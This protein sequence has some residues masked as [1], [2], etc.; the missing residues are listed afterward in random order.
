MARPRGNRR[1]RRQNAATTVT[2]VTM[3]RG[4]GR[5]ARRGTPGQNAPRARRQVVTQTTTSSTNVLPPRP[6][7]R[8]RLNRSYRSGIS[9]Q[10]TA[11]LGTV[12][13][14]DGKQVELEMSSILNPAL[15]KETTGA[16][17]FGPLQIYA[18]TYTLWKLER[19]S[20][21]L[22]PLV[23][24]S[25][26]SGTAVRVSFTP[27][28]QPGSPSWSA[29][30]AR[31]HAD[32]TPG[33]QITFSLKGSDLKGPKEGWFFCN[34]SN[35]PADCMGGSIQVHTFGAT[36]STYKNEAF[37]GPLFLAELRGVWSFR[38]YDPQP[39]MLNLVRQ[40]LSENAGQIKLLSKP[41][42]P[43]LMEVP[44]N[45]PALR[46]FASGENGASL[47]EV[48][49]QIVDGA[50][51]AVK[52][53]LPAP[54]SW[55][56]SAGWWFVK[57][58]VNPTQSDTTPGLG[59]PSSGS[60]VYRVYQS[61]QDAQNDRPCIATSSAAT[62]SITFQQ[63]TVQQITPSGSGLQ[64]DSF[65][66]VAAIP[67][68]PVQPALDPTQPIY[69]Y[70][71]LVASVYDSTSSDSE[72]AFPS[73]PFGSFITPFTET[74]YQFAKAF[75]VRSGSFYATSATTYQ[76]NPIDGIMGFMQKDPQRL[77]DISNLPVID[78]LWYRNADTNGF[79]KLG[80]IIG[81]NTT[82]AT[83]SGE[84]PKRIHAAYALWRAT[85]TDGADVT[86]ASGKYIGYMV[87]ERDA[88][89]QPQWNSSIHWSA[90]SVAKTL[91]LNI[92]QGAYYI[93]PFV[94]Y[95]GIT[96]FFIDQVPIPKPTEDVQADLRQKVFFLGEDQAITGFLPATG[97]PVK[98]YPKGVYASE[99][100]GPVI[101]AMIERLA[102]SPPDY[103]DSDWD[104]GSEEDDRPPTPLPGPGES[105]DS[106]PGVVCQKMTSEARV[107][108]EDLQ[109]KGLPV[110]TARAAANKCFPHPVHDEWEGAFQSAVLDGL[111]PPSARSFAWKQVNLLFRSR[112]HAE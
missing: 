9:Q 59:E 112:G 13:A 55:L 31:K 108:F 25:A 86:T 103:S 20:I 40:T 96:S 50:A 100:P 44:E 84:G 76:L 15:I 56:F 72:R 10:V 97:V 19:L 105:Y 110:A 107:L 28:T 66:T 69:F 38:D 5:R 93:T 42:E 58:I 94:A 60:I 62:E 45:S 22:T 8:R 52:S 41:G 85:R 2:T 61:I 7:R 79:T 71:K 109:A 17:Q 90:W 89:V 16:N 47:G 88:T 34:T 49:W 23:G 91:R 83:S 18:A 95:Q 87:M 32:T 30:G 80:D 37:G 4:S 48:I 33:R 29:L 104:T 77:V 99:N 101:A 51:D 1:N 43:I 21:R 36:Q 111:S 67:Q 26:V 3:S 35:D 75:S 27:S 78:T 65:Q 11:T 46:V 102:L 53:A 92:T 12:G 39:G 74:D 106:Q 68:V 64:Q 54:F 6:Q 82:V 81:F 57:R 63:L 70:G 98:F 24:S 14:N 73:Q